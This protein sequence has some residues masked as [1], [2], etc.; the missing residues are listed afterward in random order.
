MFCDGKKFGVQIQAI[1]NEGRNLHLK[2]FDAGLGCHW[3]FAA[4]ELDVGAT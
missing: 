1:Q 2:T 3:R 4:G